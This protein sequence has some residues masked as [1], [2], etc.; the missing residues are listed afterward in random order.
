MYAKCSVETGCF[1]C[2]LSGVNKHRGTRSGADVR[3]L[4]I[5]SGLIG[6]TLATCLRE[7]GS[8]VIVL[9]REAE[10]GRVGSFANGGLLTPSMAEPWNAPGSWGVLLGSLGRP[11]AALK[12]RV[13]ALPSL[14]KWGV[15]FMRHSDPKT[16]E[17][18]ALCNLRLALY[19][20]RAMESLRQRTGVQYDRSCV[21]SLRIFRDYAAFEQACAVANT[22][23]CQGLS[24]RRLS[25]AETIQFEPAL[26]PIGPQLKGAIHY[27][28]D[29]TGNAYQFCQELAKY[30]RQRGV[31]FRYQTEASALEI[32][33]GRL[34]G[35][36]TKRGRVVADAYVVAAG[37]HST[38]LLRDAGIE[39]AV[40]PVKGYSV[41]FAPAQE[42][43]RLRVPI[44]DDRLH[45]VITPLG[46]ILRVAGTAE[47]TGY[48]LSLPAARVHN[49]VRM[50]QEVLPSS[51]FEVAEASPW[52]G[53]R[54]VSADGVPIIGKTAVE[55][56]FVSTGHGHLGWTL[57][58]GSAELLADMI[59]GH[60]PVLDP[61]PFA[62]SRFV[63]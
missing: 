27:E 4:I 43:Q 59:D 7:R 1:S 42:G 58:A 6:V 55:N 29:E 10:A 41:S 24:F 34:T 20:L 17:R 15:M 31:E 52:C 49:L 62:I 23:A 40:R 63:R 3:V 38:K 61:R 45:A 25:A 44:V 57:A 28:V 36:I 18:N 60:E 37:S 32:R 39:L 21:G 50:I 48:D 2:G 53:L 35:V 56:L 54:P 51:K 16:F 26:A 8:D 11:D 33:S 9:D 46:N 30:A 14:W 19:S 22:R 5:G 47:F 13:K 12:L